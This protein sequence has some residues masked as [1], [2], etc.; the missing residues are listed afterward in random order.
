MKYLLFIF[1]SKIKNSNNSAANDIKQ[2]KKN[3]HTQKEKKRM[4][5]LMVF[6]SILGPIKI[7]YATR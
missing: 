2:K 4:M 7:S 5:S 6:P 3:T 1:Y